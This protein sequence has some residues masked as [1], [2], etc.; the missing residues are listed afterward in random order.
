M[1]TLKIA[2]AAL[3]MTLAMSGCATTAA[4][5]SGGVIGG[6]ACIPGGI[7]TVCA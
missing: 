6:G 1:K 2:I 3:M 7:I 5:G 4:G